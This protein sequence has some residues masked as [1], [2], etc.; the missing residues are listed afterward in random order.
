LPRT[1]RT[2]YAILF[3]LRN[4]PMSGYDIKKSC[5]EFLGHF[6]VESFGQIYPMLGRL[7]SEGAIEAMP[8]LEE[9]RRRRKTYRI[10]N[11]GHQSLKEWIQKPVIPP[12]VRDELLLKLSCGTEVDRQVH[13]R[14]LER[15]REE[16]RTRLEELGRQE[17]AYLADYH[18]LP[19]LPYWLISVRGGKATQ[20]A[21][22]RWCDRSIAELRKL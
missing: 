21:R 11:L 16:A 17:I 2:R 10:T 8:G 15:A 6:W 20:E 13:I 19:D 12:K 7:E 9:D 14:H 5:E 18:G 4:S 1:S 3:L 22:L